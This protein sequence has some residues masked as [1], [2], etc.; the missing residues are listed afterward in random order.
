MIQGLLIVEEHVTCAAIRSA[1]R[2]IP[3]GNKIIRALAK[4]DYEF[5]S[6]VSVEFSKTEPLEL[7]F[8]VFDV[9]SSS[10]APAFQRKLL[11][12]SLEFRPQS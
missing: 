4:T 7:V 12:G 5:S 1:L 3:S 2:N 8:G 11:P 9:V 10:V 6:K